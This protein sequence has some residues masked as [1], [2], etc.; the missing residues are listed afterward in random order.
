MTEAEWRKCL[1]E[2]DARIAEQDVCIADLRVQIATLQELVRELYARL[3]ADSTKSNRPPSSDGLKKPTPKSL[4]KP[5]EKQVGGQPGHPGSSLS[6]IDPHTIIEHRPDARCDACGEALPEAEVIEARQVIDMPPLALEATEHRLFEA[7]CRCG[8]VC[9]ASW[10][11]FVESRVQY[12]PRVRALAVH[13]TQHHMLP[14]ERCSTILED[15]CGASISVATLQH[16]C[17][18]AANQVTPVVEEIGDALLHSPVAHADETGFRVEKRLYWLHTVCTSDLTFIYC[19]PKRGYDAMEAGGLLTRFRGI[20]IHD[21]W[22]PYWLLDCEHALCNAHLLRELTALEEDY[23]QTWAGKLKALMLEALNES[24]ASENG[25]SPNRLKHY[26]HRAGIQLGY[27]RRDNPEQFSTN[28]KRRGKQS[29]ATN[30]LRRFG[31]FRD[32]I[33][34]FA[35]DI[36]VPFTNNLAEQAI[37]MPKVKQKVS[38]C[39]RTFAG[40]QRFCVLRSYLET[41][42]K[43]GKKLLDALTQAL[44]GNPMRPDLTLIAA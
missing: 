24:K 20:L 34:R 26:Q 6:C 36:R 28:G 12:G 7:R 9:R 19:H 42:R 31:M 37:R 27:G 30:F 5:S 40:A 13:L 25:L 16:A 14:F 21:C 3:N 1:A 41:M 32:E 43:Q 11:S 18:D 22:K 38:G 17:I 10:P 29:V 23:D 2:R 15:L 39:F 35:H 4:R 8:K 33:W 44:E